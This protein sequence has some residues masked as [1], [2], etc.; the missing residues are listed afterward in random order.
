MDINIAWEDL[1]PDLTVKAVGTV[2]ISVSSEPPRITVRRLTAGGELPG[3]EQLLD[4]LEEG[5]Y[6]SAFKKQ[7]CFPLKSVASNA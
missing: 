7:F 4:R 2:Q 1:Q 6:K 3:E 5:I